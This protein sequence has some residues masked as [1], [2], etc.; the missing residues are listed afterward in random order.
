M[1]NAPDIFERILKLD[2]RPWLDENKPDTKF[3]PLLSELKDVEAS[4][5]RAYTLDFYYPFN[6]KTK[7]YRKLITNEINS[8]CNSI[9]SLILDDTDE[10]IILY[11]LNDTLNKK[12]QTLI[13]DTGKLLREN[14]YTLAYINPKATTFD[15][16]SDHKTE[17]YIMQLLKSALI[18]SYLEIETYFQKYR[19]DFVFNIDDFY[20]QLLFE[21]V[22]ESTFIKET[23]KV[24]Y[25]ENT[26]EL[27]VAADRDTSK[28]YSARSFKYIHF[29]K[30]PD[31]LKDLYDRLKSNN[32]ID[33][34]TGYRDFKKVFS[35]SENIDKPIVWT[36]KISELYYFISH[37]YTVVKLVENTNQQQW[38]IAC[39]C[40]IKPDGS[41]FDATK[42]KKQQIPARSAKN[43]EDAINLLK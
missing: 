34:T 19:K 23:P 28:N 39:E 35:G 4:F 20:T 10:D 3:L 15:V 43:I 32:F 37:L 5:N 18:V 33:S 14:D 29:D 9:I 25:I 17:T 1:K 40:F 6:A 41:K 16:D 42:L 24:I 26:A 21:P 27:S 30:N 38:K 2:L 8:Y 22:P 31:A 7:F 13:K 12:L 11:V 36:G